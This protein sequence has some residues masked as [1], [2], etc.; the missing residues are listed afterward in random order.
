MHAKVD[1][2]GWETSGSEMVGFTEPF[3]SIRKRIFE[4]DLL[5]KKYIRQKFMKDPI[6]ITKEAKEEIASTLAANKIPDTYGLRVGIKGGACSGTF[7]LGFDTASN[8]DQSYEIDGVKVIIDQRQLMYVLGVVV[9]YEDGVNGIGYTV[10]S[11][12]KPE[13]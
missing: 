5:A 3:E 6:Q 1:L 13:N 12:G 7:L 9:D 4:W 10:T 8:F 11:L 2:L